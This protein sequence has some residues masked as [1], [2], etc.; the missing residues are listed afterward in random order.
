MDA[1]SQVSA[2]RFLVTLLEPGRSK[3]EAINDGNKNDMI[4]AKM[5]LEV[6]DIYVYMYDISC[7]NQ[8]MV[9]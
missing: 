6:T 9:H 5:N 1:K 7:V 4:W 2:A 8:K 3:W